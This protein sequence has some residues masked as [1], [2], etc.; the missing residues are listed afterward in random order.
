MPIWY[1]LLNIKLDRIL[2]T[3][4][5]ILSV[6]NHFHILWIAFKDNVLLG[7]IKNTEYW[8]IL[9]VTVLFHA[10]RFSF[11][12]IKKWNHWIQAVILFIYLFLQCTFI[13]FFVIFPWL[14]H[15]LFASFP[16]TFHQL[17]SCNIPPVLMH[18]RHNHHHQN[19]HK[20][21]RL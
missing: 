19:T 8:L 3:L 7:Y 10:E 16:L 4:N 6:N 17:F 21:I 13:F 9:D 11:S 14:E 12:S 1:H 20:L 18:H 15:F 5:S 2:E